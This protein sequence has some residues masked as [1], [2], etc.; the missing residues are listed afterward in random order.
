MTE[1][2]VAERINRIEKRIKSPHWLL[3]CRSLL[4]AKT[5]SRRA[6]EDLASILISLGYK[7]RDDRMDKPL[8]RYDRYFFRMSR[9]CWRS[10]ETTFRIVYPSKMGG[11][12]EIVIDIP[13]D[14]RTRHKPA[15]AVLVSKL[16]ER[17]N[18]NEQQKEARKSR[19]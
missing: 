15:L 17:A 9:E 19:T 8:C 16:V 18:D 12:Y 4:F 7:E 10:I 5:R 11:W 6:I 1:N 13:A 14:G 2:D 3:A